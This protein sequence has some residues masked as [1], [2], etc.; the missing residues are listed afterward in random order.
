MFLLA[1]V[2]VTVSCTSKENVGKLDHDKIISLA[3]SFSYKQ[4][5]NKFRAYPWYR[6]NDPEMFMIYC[7]ALVETDKSFPSFLKQPPVQTYKSEFAQGYYDLLKGDLR[8]ALNRFSDLTGDQDGKAWGYIGLLEFALY[9]E[10]IAGMETLLTHMQQALVNQDASSIPSWVIPYYSAWYF[11]YSGNNSQVETIVRE[12]GKQ[13]DPVTLL[14]L[15]VFLLVR[16]NR[17]EEAKKAIQDMPPDLLND[18]KVIALESGLIALESGPEQSLK[19]LQEKHERFPQMWL[20]EQRYAESLIQSGKVQQGIDILKKVSRKRPFDIMVQLDLAENLLRFEKGEGVKNIFA[21]V[22]KDNVGV[23][24][25]NILMAQIYRSRGLEDK[26]QEALKT[27]KALY[28]KDP[29]LLWLTYSISMEKHDYHNARQ[30]LKTFLSIDPNE[31][32]ALVSLMEVSYLTGKWSELTAAENIIKQSNRYISVEMWDKVN[33]YNALALAAHGQ[34][35]KAHDM[36]TQIKEVGT[37]DKTATEV[38]NLRK[39]KKKQHK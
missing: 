28:P 39:G 19:Y 24:Y 16:E 13:L 21:R 4:I 2:I 32:S 30:I 33:S 8:K 17:I 23:A 10:G 22:V 18:Q 20:I 11:F 25:Y 31:V 34:F 12:Y 6:E 36:L 7:E 37:R 38:D 27:A 3:R 15:R 1:M 35:D 5:V 26:L 9:T 14:T 29:R